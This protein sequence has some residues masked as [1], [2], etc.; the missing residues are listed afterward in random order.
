MEVEPR[1]S[2]HAT[3]ASRPRMRAPNT[4][5][6]GCALI[7][8]KMEDMVYTVGS[9]NRV[10]KGDGGSI[11]GCLLRGLGELVAES[12]RVMRVESGKVGVAGGP[13]DCVRRAGGAGLLLF[14]PLLD[15][16]RDLP[17]AG[18][19]PAAKMPSTGVESLVAGD[20]F[21]VDLSIFR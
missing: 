2:F 11:G 6:R 16:E 18:I 15:V 19:L 10:L 3:N 1:F 8:E 20:A 7:L 13:G 21:P 9:T 17:P 4:V 14:L 12:D 5:A